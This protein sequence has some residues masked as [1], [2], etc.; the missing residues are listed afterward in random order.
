[1]RNALGAHPVRTGLGA[2]AL[3][4]VAGVAWWLGSPLFIRTT[5]N[6]ALPSSAPAAIATVT[7]SA[8]ATRAA[9]AAPAGGPVVLARGELQF[10]DSIH[11]GKGPVQLVRV[12]PQRFLRFENVSITNAPDVH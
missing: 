3:L 2:T 11:N 9:T 6:E 8:S 5:A 12:D 4:V 7:G 1:M 10:V